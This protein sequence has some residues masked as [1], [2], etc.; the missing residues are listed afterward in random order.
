MASM[1][2]KCLCCDYEASFDEPKDAYDAGWDI[3]PYFTLAPFCNLCPSS[4]AAIGGVDDCREQH[5][6]NH[7]KWKV[8]GR[9]EEFSVGDEI[10][11][12]E[13]LAKFREFAKQLDEMLGRNND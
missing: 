13:E 12:P 1:D 3:V 8:D 11:D 7:A 9:P 2:Y 4:P 6:S 5:A 10:T